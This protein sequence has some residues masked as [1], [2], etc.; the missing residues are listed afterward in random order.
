MADISK[1]TIPSGDSYNF[2]DATARGGLPRYGTC[3]TA[4][5]TAAKVITLTDTSFQLVTGV[6]ICVKFTTTNTANNPTFNVNNTGAKSVWYN[7]AL[8]T[9]S[10]N[11]YAGTANRPMLYMYDGTQWVFIGQAYDANT[12]YTNMTQTEATTGI[13][14][15]AR[16]ISAKV[17]NDTI[18]NKVTAI[19]NAEI[20]GIC[21]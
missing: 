6:I 17:L 3:S 1:I 14:T 18:N 2:K 8:I 10:N 15:T 11:G 19:T 20:D 9:T 13:A 21:V 16:S 7:T 12:T 5:A 4:A